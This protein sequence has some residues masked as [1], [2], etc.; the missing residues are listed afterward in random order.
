MFYKSIYVLK[1]Y[2]KFKKIHIFFVECK[3]DFNLNFK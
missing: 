1:A 3:I 2:E